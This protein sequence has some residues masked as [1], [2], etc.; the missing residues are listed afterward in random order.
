MVL[1][2]EKIKQIQKEK[3]AYM[4]N[5]EL[6]IPTS[7]YQQACIKLLNS[8]I[9]TTAELRFYLDKYFSPYLV[10]NN[11]N[12]IG[13]FTAYYEAALEA[14]RHKSP[15]YPYPIYGTPR[16]LIEIN[17]GDEESKTGISKNRISEFLDEISAFSSVKVRGMMT[18]APKCVETE[19]YR[20]Y[21]RESYH[22]FIDFCEKKLN[23]VS[24]CTLSMGMSD[25][26]PAALAE[27]ASLIR[28]GR[29]AFRKE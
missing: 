7:A 10:L 1:N 13:K 14:S 20:K 28:V 25:S 18:M 27:G 23:N 21:F 22:I 2:L 4:S 16:N 19:E 29:A 3:N 26:F 5:S 6:K 24:R 12:P 11:S 17:I 9:S 8:D 15:L